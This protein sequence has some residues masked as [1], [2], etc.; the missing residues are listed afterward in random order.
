MGSYESLSDIV[1]ST[2]ISIIYLKVLVTIVEIELY[3]YIERIPFN[4]YMI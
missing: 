4:L 3:F 1:N 2:A